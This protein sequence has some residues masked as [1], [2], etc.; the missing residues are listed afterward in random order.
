MKLYT[1]EHIG[2]SGSELL[3]A[4]FFSFFLHAALVALTLILVTAAAPKVHIPLFYEVKLVGQPQELAPS[5]P[6]AAAPSLPKAEP[7]TVRE[8]PQP[9]TKQTAPKPVAAA[10]KKG[11]M[12]ELAKQKQEKPPARVQ[13]E[14]QP[15]QAQPAQPAVSAPSS[16][17]VGAATTV[18]VKMS[19]GLEKPEFSY[20]SDLV[21]KKIKDNWKPLPVPKDTKVKV[22]FTVLRSGWV[23]DVKLEE[24][25]GIFQFDQAA[26][27]AIRS[28]S[29]FPQFPENFYKP[30]AVF[31]AYLT[32]E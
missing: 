23:D 2:Q 16:E 30:S 18:A 1:G 3:I 6:P 25:S 20:Y 7:A 32:P 24:E 17:K 12:P 26:I 21:R 13:P 9:K 28:S 8:K 14:T 22:V 5:P 31:S 15:Q 19:S 10:P 11:D 27:R 29:P 4:V